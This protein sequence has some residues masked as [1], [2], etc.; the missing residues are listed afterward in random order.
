MVLE[1]RNKRCLRSLPPGSLELWLCLGYFVRLLIV[2]AL[3]L[4][5]WLNC[6]RV[7]MLAEKTNTE[8]DWPKYGCYRSKLFMYVILPCLGD[9]SPPS[10]TPSHNLF[11]ALTHPRPVVTKPCARLQLS[12][13]NREDFPDWRFFRGSLSDI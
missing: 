4:G 8:S 7:R 2:H 3:P 13:P 10:N 1:R 5:G 11:I 12:S 6:N 9:G